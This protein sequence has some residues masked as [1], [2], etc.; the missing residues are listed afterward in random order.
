MG[1]EPPLFVDGTTESLSGRRAVSV[2]WLLGTV[3]TGVTSVALM[4]GALMVAMEGTTSVAA[5]TGDAV[6]AL[7]DDA[8]RT[9]KADRVQQQPA[10]PATKQVLQVST[11]SRQGDSDLIRA[12][13]Y[14]RLSAPLVT[15][16]E[17]D[18][19]DIP[20]FDPLKAFA[21][22]KLFPDRG[23]ADTIYGAAVDGEVT[24]SSVD[25]PL[26]S[27]QIDPDLMLSSDAVEQIVR[28]DS[29]FKA[30]NPENFAVRAT[31]PAAPA[32]DDVSARFALAFA[33]VGAG[34]APS[35][36]ALGETGVR[37]VPENVSEVAKSEAA[38]ADPD[39]DQAAASK[40]RGA[41]DVVVTVGRGDNLGKIL[42]SVKASPMDI[43]AIARTFAT[44][45]NVKSITPGDKI[46]IGLLPDADDPDRMKPAR[47]S[48]YDATSHLGTVALD[49]D[50]NYVAADEPQD[51]FLEDS[52]APEDDSGDEDSSGRTLTLY[53]SLYQTARKEQLPDAVVNELVRMFSFDVD[54][55]S[56]VGDGDR[57]ELFYADEDKSD[58]DS[59]PD[60]L[61]AALSVGGTYKQLYR[62]R[63]TDDGKTDYYDGAGR[64]AQKFLMRKP[65]NGGILRS[66]FGGRRHPILGYYR[67][68]AGV[69]WAAPRGTPIVASGN[70]V[71]KESGWKS[72]YG[73]WVLLG[74]ANGY[75]TGY[76]HMSRIADNMKPGTRVRQ[77]QVIGYVGSTGMSTGS[78]LHYE[79]HINTTPVDPLRVRLPQGRELRGKML[80]A[81]RKERERMEDLIHPR[82]GDNRTASAAPAAAGSTN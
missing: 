81:F 18:M 36:L 49:D 17:T 56:R 38:T 10:A 59:P 20:A 5:P 23:P 62:F 64:S 75:D 40:P 1:H 76:G 61:Y 80:T 46:R 57:L 35:G 41:S 82:P 3:L 78:H 66:G 53:E 28:E 65:M 77:G 48:V 54:F 31:A 60:L 50:G 25:F 58:P 21:D 68:H 39:A 79:V 45:A 11:I 44:E 15:T 71:V 13:P 27:P 2:R 26:A 67:M 7:A 29:L 43:K 52:A 16:A 34:E 51:D 8:S 69:D 12:R 19:S 32:S 22:T 33:A 55:N 30:T 37:I 70:G 9:G 63:T 73:K 24:V 47:V 42:R 6:M 14:V 72:G 74:H 4:G